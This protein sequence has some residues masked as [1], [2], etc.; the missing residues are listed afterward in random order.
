MHTDSEQ[1]TPVSGA[2]STSPWRGVTAALPICL[3]YLPLGLALGVLGRQAGLEPWQIGL[4]SLMVFAGSAQFIAVAMLGAGV[5]APTIVATTF[6]VNLRHLL[7][8]SSLAVNLKGAGRLFLSAF[9]YGVTD[10]SFALNTT[11]F[12]SGDWSRAQ[13]LALNQSANACWILSTWAGAYL[14]QLIPTGAFGIG[15]A[16]P[17][18]FIALLSY[19]LRQRLHIVT[20][21]AT[22][23]FSLLLYRLI[24]GNSYILIAAV[25]GA[26]LGYLL[27][28][29]KNRSGGPR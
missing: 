7:M 1:A 19:Q 18:M 24:P 2:A 14:G 20:A 4:M 26:S 8:S 10:E 28:Q 12:R 5:A 27:Q 3:G 29:R 9:A 21:L 16:L 17:A 13:A 15:F 25:L 6:M 11:R 22:G 23:A